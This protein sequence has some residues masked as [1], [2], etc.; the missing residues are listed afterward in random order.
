[1]RK[2]I[3]SI[4]IQK[5]FLVTD[6][7]LKDY[8]VAALKEVIL[9]LCPN[10]TIIDVS[11]LVHPGNIIE[12]SFIT[13]QLSLLNIS[14]SGI[15]VVVDPGVGTKRD[16]MAIFCRNENVLIGPDNGVLYPLAMALGIEKI[17]RIDYS[18]KEYFPTIS[19]TFH[20]R[21]IFARAMG[22]I[23]LGIFN[24][25]IPKS[26]M[27]K[28]DIFLYVKKANKIIFKILYVDHFGNVVTNIPCSED[29]PNTC[30]LRI[31]GKMYKL[32]LVRTFGDLKPDE[33]GILCGSSGLYEIV[34][35]LCRASKILGCEV[36]DTGELQLRKIV[37]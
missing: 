24:I 11:H 30:I 18:N 15:L 35:N 10:V 20:G 37:Y 14:K 2:T 36:G 12:G 23:C 31:R 29:I 7:G 9:S 21:D 22:Y 17:Y 32:K 16:P 25:L 3:R 5:I 4:N 6:F 19:N 1:M 26:N 28:N 13:W 34:C 27:V 8:Y 33:L